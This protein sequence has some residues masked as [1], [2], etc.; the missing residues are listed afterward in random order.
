V[1]QQL[2]SPISIVAVSRAGSALAQ[3]IAAALPGARALLPA[4]FAAADSCAYEGGVLAAVAA[5]FE[6][7]R[8][9][10]LI[11]ASGIAVRAVAP[12]LRDKREDPAV[13]VVDDAGRFVISLVGGH[14]GGAN[15]LATRIA[16]AIGAVP[17]ITTAS[18]A[19]GLPALD[20]IASERGWRVDAGSDLTRVSAA[21]VNGEPMAVLQ[22][23][24]SRDWLAAAGA[25]RLRTIANASETG[26]DDAAA[27]VISCRS[28]VALPPTLLRVIMRPPVLMLGAGCSRGAPPEELIGL[29]EAVL[30][31][32]GLAPACV[33]AV[34]TID[35][36]CDDPAMA[37]LAARFAVP[38]LSFSSAEL[39]A[40][41]GDWQ[42][43][44]IVLSAVGAGGVCE[45]AAILAARGG[46]LIVSKRKSAHATIAVA[47]LTEDG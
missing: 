1:T 4:R 11:M 26:S 28:E 19:A 32:A 45:P 15:T 5:E 3:R 6:W 37:A 40:A 29:A 25:A 46:A 38:T 7:A 10:V 30:D 27:I 21:L 31:E 43:S 22:D 2:P 36:R 47:H 12:L 9:L 35:R 44:A 24:G 14:L 18:E 34:A 33:A 39:N 41:P 13:V 42:R 23:R 8:G 17:V 16:G 20:M